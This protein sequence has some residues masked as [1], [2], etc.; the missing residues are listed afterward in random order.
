MNFNSISKKLDTMAETGNLHGLTVA[1]F[2]E[3]EYITAHIERGHRVQT[4]AASVADFMKAQG[5]KV[6]P[7]GTGWAIMA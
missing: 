4:I 3:I 1:E 6:T 5:A 2:R 7:R